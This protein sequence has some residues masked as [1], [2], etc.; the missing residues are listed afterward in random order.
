VIVAQAVATIPGAA[1]QQH[2]RFKTIAGIELLSLAS[3]IGAAI[4]IALA[5][6]G[7]W[8]LVWQQIVFYVMRGA[9]SYRRSP[10]R[11]GR[12]FSMHQLSEHL[13]FGRDIL[14]VAVVQLF[15]RTAD[16]MMIGK[17]LGSASVGLYSMAFQFARLP[18]MLVTGP[19]QYV[20]YAQLAQLKAHRR[21]IGETYLMINRVL[22]II[23]F[24]GMA[25]VA[26]AH[27]PVFTWLLSEK[28][29]KSA[30]L[31]MIL[32]PVC[33]LQ[34][35]TSLSNTILMVMART[36]KQLR[37]ATEFALLWVGSLWL[38][39]PYGLDACALAY[40]IAVLLFTPRQLRVL[41]PLIECSLK[42]YIGSFIVPGVLSLAAVAVYLAVAESLVT[43][44]YGRIAL[45]IM[46]ALAA[47]GLSAWVQKKALLLEVQSCRKNLSA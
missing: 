25:M 5:G 18:M 39:V 42:R 32:A 26:V 37:L 13:S 20:L 27:E 21:V 6:G 40:N 1:L 36:D 47:M 44:M 41:L 17:A 15:S 24:P 9:L 2:H 8:A 31:F 46:L 45:S 3:G 10:F 33:T 23:I 28:W 14:S 16:S 11:P 43:G 34:T 29:A 30:H 22:A 35:I 7:A 12:H 4:A 19:L 38:A